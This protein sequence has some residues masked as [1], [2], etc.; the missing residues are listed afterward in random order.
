[1]ASIKRANIQVLDVTPYGADNSQSGTVRTSVATALNVPE[2]YLDNVDLTK[3]MY[4]FK[5]MFTEQTEDNPVYS[6]TYA[7]VHSVNIGERLRNAMSIL[8]IDNGGGFPESLPVVGYIE[9]SP[10]PAYE[11]G[12]MIIKIEITVESRKLIRSHTQPIDIP[13][14]TFDDYVVKYDYK[15]VLTSK[16][17]WVKGTVYGVTDGD[18]IR[19]SVEEQNKVG[20][21]FVGR[22]LTVR[23]VGVL[24]PETK[25]DI[26]TSW[27]NKNMEWAARHG[28]EPPTE[29]NGIMDKICALAEEARE[30]V[31]GLVL[32]KKVIVIAEVDDN[33]IPG[34]QPKFD[35]DGRLVGVVYL[36]STQ[37]YTG[38]ND[39]ELTI[40]VNTSIIANKSKRFPEFALGEPTYEYSMDSNGTIVSKF[41]I[42][43]WWLYAPDYDKR[44]EEIRKYELEKKNSSGMQAF[45]DKYGLSMLPQTPLDALDNKVELVYNRQY[46]VKTGVD[47]YIV[48]PGDT[49]SSIAAEFGISVNELTNQIGDIDLYPGRVISIDRY[50]IFEDNED[51]LWEGGFKLNNY[52]LVPA[53]CETEDYENMRIDDRNRLDEQ[54]GFD[55]YNQFKLRIGDCMFLVP[56]LSIHVDTQASNVRLQTLRSKSSMQIQSGYSDTV[57]TID[58]FF[59]NLESV[60]GYEMPGPKG[61]TYYR[62][63]L[64]PLIAQFKRAPF[65][66]IENELLNERFNI[67]AVVLKDL[68]IATVPGFPSCLQARLT[69]LQFDHTVYMP[70]EEDFASTFCWPLFRWFYQRSLNPSDK[71][72]RSY[73][74]KL[75]RL[76]DTISFSIPDEAVLNER[77]Q[78]IYDLVNKI[79]P[80]LFREANIKDNTT[81]GEILKEAEHI[82]MAREQFDRFRQ[83]LKRYPASSYPKMYN[84]SGLF[85]VTEIYEEVRELISG[86]SNDSSKAAK[87]AVALYNIVAYTYFGTSTMHGSATAYFIMYKMREILYIINNMAYR[88]SSDP[89]WS[90]VKD[91]SIA[92]LYVSFTAKST[93]TVQYV[94]NRFVSSPGVSGVRSASVVEDTLEAGSPASLYEK[95]LGDDEAPYSGGMYI[96]QINSPVNK[97][98]VKTKLG[99]TN[100]YA[101]NPYDETLVSIIGNAEEATSLFFIDYEREFEKLNYMAHLSEADIPSAE[102]PIDDIY[103]ES[104]AARMHNIYTPLQIL[105]A[106]TPTYQ[107]LGSSDAIIDLTIRTKNREAV[108]RFRQLMS[109]AQRLA[110]EY[111]IAITSGV[112]TINTPLTSLLGVKSVLIERLSVETSQNDK[113]SFI[114]NISFIAFDKTQRVKEELDMVAAYG[115]LEYDLQSFI[116]T[117]S[118]RRRNESGFEY[119]IIDFTLRELELYPDLELPTY[120]EVNEILPHLKITYPNGMPFL[121]YP[122]PDNAKF[123]DPDFYIRCEH[124]FRD[125]VY[126]ILEDGQVPIYMTDQL[127]FEMFEVTPTRG[128]QINGGMTQPSA[129]YSDETLEWIEQNLNEVYVGQRTDKQ[130]GWG[131]TTDIN[132]IQTTRYDPKTIPGAK[133]NPNEIVKASVGSMG[134][135]VPEKIKATITKEAVIKSPTDEEIKR[136]FNLNNASDNV[137]ASIRANRF[138]NPTEAEFVQYLTE[139]VCDDNTGFFR[140]LPSEADLISS[141]NNYLYTYKYSDNRISPPKITREK[142]V[143]VL[144]A[145]YDLESGWKQFDGNGIPIWSKTNDIGIA[146]LNAYTSGILQNLDQA[147]RAAWDWKYNLYRGVEFF[148]QQYNLAITHSDKLGNADAK[149]NPLDWAIVCY[150]KGPE[151]GLRNYSDPNQVDYYNAVMKRFKTKY[152]ADPVYVGATPTSLRD[153]SVANSQIQ[154]TEKLQRIKEYLSKDKLYIKLSKFVNDSGLAKI[155]S[156]NQ[157]TEATRMAYEGALYNSILGTDVIDTEHYKN[158]ANATSPQDIVFDLTEYERYSLYARVIN[159]VLVAD[160]TGQ[161]SLYDNLVKDAGSTDTTKQS[162]WKHRKSK[163]QGYKLEDYVKEVIKEFKTT[164]TF[165]A[166]KQYIIIKEGA[167]QYFFDT[168]V[169]AITKLEQNNYPYSSPYFKSH[170]IDSIKSSI[171]T[172]KIYE[173]ADFENA[174]FAEIVI[175][176]IDTQDAIRGA[177]ISPDDIAILYRSAFK[178]IVEYDQRGRLVR[179]FP[180]YQM[181]IIDEGRWM[182]WHKLWDNFYGYNAIVSID[183]CRDRKIAADT[184]VITLANIYHNLT[185]YDNEVS[186]GEWDYTLGDLIWGNKYAKQ[187]VWRTIWDLPDDEILLARRDEL[188]TLMLKP[189]ARI[190]LRMGYGSNAYRLPVVFN[191]V[192]TEMNAGEIVTIMAQGDGIELCNKLRVSPGDTNESGWFITK[193]TIEPRDFMCGL[194]TSKGSFLQNLANRVS[195]GVFYNSNP[196]G[197]VHF[198]VT[199]MPDAVLLRRWDMFNKFE[200]YGECGQNIYCSA[201]INTLSQWVYTEGTKK[202]QEFGFRWNWVDINGSGQGIGDEPNV[203]INL[204][205][206]T[207][208]GVMQAFAHACPDYIVTVVPFEFRSTV[209]Y[210][211]PWWGVIDRY[212][213]KY[214][215]DTK[216]DMFVREPY[217]YERRA[218]S[219]LKIYTDHFDIIKNDIKATDEFMYTNVIGV[220]DD[221]KKRTRVVQLDS[222]IAPEKQK[223]AIINL[224]YDSDVWYKNFWTQAKYAEAAAASA[225][226]DYVKDMYQG[227]LI[228]LGD[229]TAKPYD[230]FYINDSYTDMA[231]LAEIQRVVHHFS[232][233]TGFVTSITPDCVSVIDD[234]QGISLNSWLAGTA[235]GAVMFTIGMLTKNTMWKKIW[236]SP[237]AAL[238]RKAGKWTTNKIIVNVLGKMAGATDAELKTL[239]NLSDDLCSYLGKLINPNID[240][241]AKA[242]ARAADYQQIK[243]GLSKILLK[244]KTVDGVVQDTILT[245]MA[246]IFGNIKDTVTTKGGVARYID[247]LKIFKKSAIVTETGFY[248]KTLNRLWR[249]TSKLTKFTLKTAGEGTA[250]AIRGTSA[251]VVRAGA[252]AGTA[253]LSLL[254]EIAIDI[255]ISV[256]INSVVERHARWLKARQALTII[257]LNYRGKPFVAGINGHKGVIAGED[258]SA[259]DKFLMGSGFGKTAINAI[260]AI[261]GITPPDY[262]VD[263]STAQLRAFGM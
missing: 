171:D 75:N 260:Y 153:A 103:I 206:K 251:L 125:Y 102:F 96:I 140:D 244:T 57:I 261:F 201:G 257:P 213:Y 11:N 166:D 170:M 111:R 141:G 185:T 234:M 77:K 55:P 108:E 58:L 97:R 152:G 34:D 190:H 64:R 92:N 139:I 258:C 181:F 188:N 35:K 208:W 19:I 33:N 241:A 45:L 120:E 129:I 65:L 144:K 209:F 207:P 167:A 46:K 42:H 137:I 245:K 198:G 1:M 127:G 159:D 186:Y 72:E 124:T 178:D 81:V 114:I 2:S 135:K 160:T 255:A 105:S 256:L 156:F 217:S 47:S 221:G 91:S 110:R 49:L 43:T 189:G 177:I 6:T 95:Y 154:A 53:D 30:F 25:K 41:D 219:Q 203:R 32:N 133:T 21:E 71:P 89:A 122:N 131:Y 253:G 4:K 227:E 63:G 169:I 193:K 59:P 8:N 116:D 214:Y 200:D 142:V 80:R 60:N 246:K 216:Y 233:E 194:L 165:D 134:P 235:I 130:T 212:K 48:Q 229:P 100:Y 52:N 250:A 73:Y 202:G 236:G 168:A 218:L 146:Q 230:K 192:I 231:G 99:N 164:G 187:K 262:S 23:L 238:F 136:W 38:L 147:R 12:I 225:L 148:A 211:K 29:E 174:E 94:S 90:M 155:L 196:L 248:T 210:G 183:L 22:P 7:V 228:V 83:A 56:P 14:P 195:G 151:S 126:A 247:D 215:Y 98:R 82:G 67:Y 249:G 13:R 24:C 28:L 15:P 163:L 175:D 179:A 70:Q 3:N 123:V 205:D 239:S 20:S 161:F 204:F 226:R 61:M 44:V 173:I 39:Q 223:T 27:Y 69:L 101:I 76:D 68:E 54:M 220:W 93:I 180:T 86:R 232:M 243:E 158:I 149:E 150:N 36:D 79:H 143:N 224:P 78:A 182:A 184:C 222:D 237:I 107:H 259:L 117:Y 172:R 50:E 9:Y 112:L 145:L 74:A 84:S 37:G 254:I 162:L 51:D 85:D 109:T 104:M 191:G 18:T 132:A 66:P 87:Y 199:S 62:N 5:I 252:A 17:M 197:I 115:G 157:K 10:N 118:R 240:D 121:H 40:C 176:S 242:A 263:S 128:Q 88:F 138:K 26:D 106:E 119:A 31:E 16:D 113:E